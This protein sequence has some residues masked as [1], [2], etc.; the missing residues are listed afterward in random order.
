[1]GRGPRARDPR[2]AAPPQATRLPPATP[3][4]R[5][6]GELEASVLEWHARPDHRLGEALDPPGLER[7]D[8]GDR[9]RQG[10]E[11]PGPQPHRPRPARPPHEAPQDPEDQRQRTPLPRSHRKPA[12]GR[13]GEASALPHPLPGPPERWIARLSP[14][15][16]QHPQRRSGDRAR[17]KLRPREA[18]GEARGRRALAP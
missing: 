13:A 5:A 4:P 6:R 9:E 11:A 2:A 8:R 18:R 14:L 1:G 17:A 16:A 7:G 3:N 10:R 15:A 12:A